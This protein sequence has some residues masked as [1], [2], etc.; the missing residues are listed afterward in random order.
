MAFNSQNL[1]DL[2]QLAIKHNATDIHIRTDEVPSLRILG[3]LIPIQTRPF[4]AQDIR[5]ICAILIQDPSIRETLR[6]INEWDGG[7]TVEGVCRLRMNIFRFSGKVGITLRV[8][9]IHIPTLEELNLPSAV[10]KIAEISRGLVLVTGTTGSGKTTT[11]AAMINHLNQNRGLHIV[12][13][14]DPIEY[15]HSSIKSRITQREIGI[16]TESFNSGLRSALRQDPDVILVGE[17]RDGDTLS[18]A[19]KAAETGH[20]VF[21]TLHT[22]NAIAT[23]NRILSLFPPTEQNEVRKRL[24][25]SLSA[26]IGQRLIR[27]K[28]GTGLV[29]AMEVMISNMNIRDCILGN[30][31]MERMNDYIAKGKTKGGNGSR[32]YDQHLIELFEARKIS[33]EEALEAA[34]SPNDFL[35]NLEVR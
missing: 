15:V 8:L 21:A 19:L 27:K 10:T 3:E 32:T 7:Y 6:D 5:D 33:K 16:D 20:V 4:T 29:P 9:K 1:I 11:L 30:E 35:Q 34:D 31:P 22:T 13:L 26:T 14:E 23:V 18:T 24:A 17:L 12:T 28:N 2:V 25:D